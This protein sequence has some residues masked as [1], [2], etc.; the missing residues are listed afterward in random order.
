MLE[1]RNTQVVLKSVCLDGGCVLSR[2]MNEFETEF[3]YF[4]NL[5]KNIIKIVYIIRPP[6][7]SVDPLFNI[8]VTCGCVCLSLFR[9]AWL[10]RD[11]T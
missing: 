3:P 8:F 6:P 1:L 5:S 7:L 11:F 2:W 10:V 9:S 4:H